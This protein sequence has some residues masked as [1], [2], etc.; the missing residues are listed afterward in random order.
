MIDWISHGSIGLCSG[1]IHPIILTVGQLRTASVIGRTPS[2]ARRICDAGSRNTTTIQIDFATHAELD[3]TARA[4]FKPL[5]NGG[6][7]PAFNIADSAITVGVAIFAF[8]VMFRKM[9]G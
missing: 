5:F 3:A 9:P 8:H 6:Y 4:V 7:F 2:I 1:A